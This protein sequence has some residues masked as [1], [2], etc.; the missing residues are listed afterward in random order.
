[1]GE[2][3]WLA[4]DGLRGVAVLMVVADHGGFV[5]RGPLGA[6][7]V[8]I[9]FVLS[10]FLITHVIVQARERGEWSMRRF[11]FARVVRLMPALIAMEVVVT[12]WWLLEATPRDLVRA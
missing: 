6:A 3:R 1:M 5:D 4:L 10:G 9:F 11:L 2:R 8:T 12:L 7:G